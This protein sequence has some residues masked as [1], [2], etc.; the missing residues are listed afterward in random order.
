MTYST[1]FIYVYVAL[2]IIM[3]KDYPYIPN[4]STLVTCNGY[5]SDGL[6]KYFPFLYPCCY[7]ILLAITD[8]M[9][10]IMALFLYS[11]M[12]WMTQFNFIFGLVHAFKCS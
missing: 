9:P 4:A 3:V 10:E 6:I 1:H 12:K 2:D 8:N 11:Y 7:S 5:F